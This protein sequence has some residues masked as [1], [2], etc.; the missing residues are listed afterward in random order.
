[1]SMSISQKDEQYISYY[2]HI[3]RENDS[4]ESI[5]NKYNISINDLKEYNDIDK[6]ALGNKIIIPYVENDKGI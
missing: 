3:V 2:V 1:M 6:I 4:I 5:S